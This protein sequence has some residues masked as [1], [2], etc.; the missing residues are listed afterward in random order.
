MNKRLQNA[1]IRKARQQE[2]Q[3]TDTGQIFRRWK[4][5]WLDKGEDGASWYREY[6]RLPSPSG[7]QRIWGKTGFSWTPWAVIGAATSAQK[8]SQEAAALAAEKAS[9]EQALNKAIEDSITRRI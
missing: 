8:S 2:S 3:A 5:T 4:I 9:A 1:V 6:E 7:D